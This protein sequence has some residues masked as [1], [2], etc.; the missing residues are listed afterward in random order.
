MAAAWR[1]PS[2]GGS[3]CRKSRILLVLVMQLLALKG[4]T[5]FSTMYAKR[6]L[7]TFPSSLLSPV[8]LLRAL[9]DMLF[10]VGV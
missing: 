8:L 4:V 9:S 2:S 6:C 5:P 3:Q 7:T 1:W 10:T